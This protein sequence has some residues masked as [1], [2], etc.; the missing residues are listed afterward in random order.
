MYKIFFIISLAFLGVIFFA[1]E[2]R[3]TTATGTIVSQ[4]KDTGVGPNWGEISWTASTTAS[5][6]I[7][8]KIRTATTSDMSSAADWAGCNAIASGTDIS[9]NNCVTDGQCYLQY[10]AY[11]SADYA[12]ATEFVSP[13]LYEVVIKYEATGILTSSA[14]N[15]LAD[16]TIINQARWGETKPAGTDALVQLRT[17]ADGSSWSVWMGSDGTAEDYFTDPL[18]GESIPA[19]LSDGANDQYLQYRVILDSGGVDLPVLSDITIDYQSEVPVI[20]SVSPGFAGSNASGT[21]VFTISGSDFKSG[22]TVKL[23]SSGVEISGTEV[24]A[25]ANEIS[26]QFDLSSAFGGLADIVVTNPNTA[27]DTW[28]DFYINEYQGVYI[29]QAKDVPNLY[30]NVLSWTAATSATSSVSFK[31]RTDAKSDMSGATAWASC[32]AAVNGADISGNNC[33][34]DGQRYAQ[35]R[36]ALSAVYGTST[37]WLTP[38]LG[39][40]TLGYARY[41]ASGTLVSSPYDTG[42]AAN[43]L[44]LI[45]WSE[46]APAG[47]DVLFQIRAAPDS[48]GV[49]GTWSDWF[50]LY[51]A[52]GYYRNPG[53]QGG[54]YLGQTDGAGDQW[55]QYRA[56][57]ESAGDMVPVLSDITINYGS[58][59]YSE[60]IIND[61]VILKD[62]VIFR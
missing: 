18:G 48:S 61:N 9:S 16:D 47:T 34:S 29:S 14:Y 27:A 59:Q 2:S 41:A 28:S 57:L 26:C 19:A 38:E 49:P 15:T 30:F 40:A 23:V 8:M 24:S 6:S 31:I 45:S 36:V 1:G 20:T 50:G 25:G 10:R 44:S 32:D 22:S 39:E 13:E 42:S 43:A 35:Y 46:S 62:S 7:T 33:V 53:G 5:S 56:R 4:I 51:A 52:D 17:S 11:F 60:T 21:V 58:K 37:G 54:I 3:A 12:T 55:L